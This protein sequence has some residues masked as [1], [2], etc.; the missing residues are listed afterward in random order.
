MIADTEQELHIM[1]DRLNLNRKW[2]QKDASFPHYDI[3]KGY[4]A[5][6]LSMGAIELE[7]RPFVYKMREIKKV[8]KYIDGHPKW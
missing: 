4:K 7:R 1:A 8:L 5:K 2:F 3:S 6:A